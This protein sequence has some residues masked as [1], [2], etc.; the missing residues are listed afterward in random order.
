MN[1]LQGGA[2][3]GL[4]NAEVV[5]DD[6]KQARVRVEG[7]VNGQ[8]F[9]IERSVRGRGKGKLTFELDSADLTMA[10]IKLTQA[11]VDRHLATDMLMRAVFHGQADITALSEVRGCDECDSG[12]GLHVIPAGTVG[13]PIT[14]HLSCSS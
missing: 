10:E 3:R 1:W 5:N 11:E 8:D 7:R 12:C 9:A 2:G 4:T 6:C 14:G 13:S